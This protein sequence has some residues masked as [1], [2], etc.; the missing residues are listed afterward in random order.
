MTQVM[1]M[2]RLA[3][4]IQEHVLSMPDAV[5]RPAISE[6]ALR[7]IAQLEDQR[8]QMETFQR[9]LVSRL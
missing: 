2:L 6:R 1:G 8:R 4:E 9:A 7:P 3:P 5:R